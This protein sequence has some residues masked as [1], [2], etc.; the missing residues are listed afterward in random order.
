MSCPA[1]LIW[2]CLPPATHA[3][4]SRRVSP[5]P[6][7]SRRTPQCHAMHPP[8]RLS[9]GTSCVISSFVSPIKAALL[10][11]YRLKWA[12]PRKLQHTSV[13]RLAHPLGTATATGRGH[14]SSFWRFASDLLAGAPAA[15]G[16]AAGAAAGL[17][18]QN[19]CCSCCCACACACTSAAAAGSPASAAAAVTS[20]AAAAVTSS[21]AATVCAAATGSGPTLPCSSA[22]SSSSVTVP[23]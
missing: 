6:S 13:C 15:A 12:V 16:P 5:L 8:A 14:S 11:S 2:A 22:S 10:Q 21:A 4:R 7:I 1:R 18:K 20:S 17:S 23:K 9:A 19:C 3:N